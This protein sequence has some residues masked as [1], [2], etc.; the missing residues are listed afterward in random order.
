[1]NRRNANS[2]DTEVEATSVR[3]KRISVGLRPKLA[4]IGKN[5]NYE[6]RI[7]NDT[8]GRISMFKSGGWELCTN[9]EVD[10]GTYRAEEA[11]EV[12]SLAYFIVDGG[13][14]L[15][16]YVMKIRKDWYKEFMAE[17]EAEV[18]ST[19]ESLRP[20]KNDGGYGDFNIDR[21]GKR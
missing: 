17:H 15:K 16:A 8:P 13:T 19:E 5:D 1:M 20:N 21:S 6:Y 11:S 14:G 3:P 7:V 4:I 18:R 10:T 12:G 2:V 9:D